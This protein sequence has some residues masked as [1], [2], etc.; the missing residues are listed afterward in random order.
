MRGGTRTPGPEGAAPAREGM[1]QAP[2]I[3]DRMTLRLEEIAASLGISRRALE[4]VRSA[5][6]FPAPDI[7]IGK[8][9]LWRPETVRGWLDKGGGCR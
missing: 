6:N 3:P 8:V 4:R 1:A 7:R 9:P 5:G 2:P